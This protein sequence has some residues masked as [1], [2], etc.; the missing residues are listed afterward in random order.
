MTDSVGNAVHGY[1]LWAEI[2]YAPETVRARRGY[3]RHFTAWLA[4]RGV[5]ETAQLNP[6]VLGRYQRDIRRRLGVDHR[7]IGPGAVIQ[8]LLAVRGF[9]RWSAQRRAVGPD[10]AT[11]I[12]LPHR[13]RPLPAAV[14]TA[15]AV[16]RVLAVPDVASV[17]GLRDRAILELL[18]ATGLRRA[19]V[20]RLRLEEVDWERRTVWVRHGKGGRDRVVPAGARALCWMERYLRHA[21]PAL[22]HGRDPGCIFLTC[23][24]RELSPKHLGERVGTYLRRAQVAGR[25]SCH[26][27]RHTMATLM[28]ERGADIRCLQAILGH[29]RLT[30][31]E[32]YTRVGIA[33]LCAIHARTHPAESGH[34]IGRDAP[35]I[36]E[37]R[38]VMS[39]G[40]M[41]ADRTV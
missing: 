7:P 12:V 34:P 23:R 2:T 13:P 9:L 17:L 8:R 14:L 4:D 26:I 41:T 37:P 16:E 3:L 11:A 19:E 35:S 18:Y 25:G 36:G 24:G 20:T 32:I 39:G 38:S 27:F 31:T 29:A 40:E 21:R 1:L 30:T 28:F 22:I 5:D 15:T 6:E 10:L 33:Q